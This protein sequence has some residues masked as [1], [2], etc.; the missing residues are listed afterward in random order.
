MNVVSG[1]SGRALRSQWTAEIDVTPALAASLIREQFPGLAAGRVHRAGSGWD[2]NAF[3]VDGQWLFRFP[4]RQLAIPGIEREIAVLP[5]LAPRL[6]LPIP[7]P[8]FAGRP[9]ASY[10][11]PFF[12]AR[13]LAGT[14]FADAGIASPQRERAA[15]AVGGFL[16]VLHDPELSALVAD[17]DLPADP[18]GRAA[19]PVRAARAANSLER[20]AERGIWSPDPDVSGLLGQARAAGGD[21]AAP[22]ARPLALCHGDLHFRHMLVDESGAVTGVIDWGDLCLGDPA[23]DLSVAYLAFDARARDE[24][25]AAYSRPVGQA[26]ELAARTCALS[27]AAALAEYAADDDRPALLRESLAGIRRSVT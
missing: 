23:I 11:W 25:L 4:R 10:G 5:R 26:R 8:R 22:A 18:M 27:L 24:L 15:A 2:N 6:P 14:E 21:Q 17:A 20:L 12:G 3:V 9:S 1:A 13:M 19:P 7:E 16:R